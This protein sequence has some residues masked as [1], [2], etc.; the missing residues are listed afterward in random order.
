MR[1]KMDIYNALNTFAR[2]DANGTK[3]NAIQLQLK[4]KNTILLTTLT[5]SNKIIK[6]GM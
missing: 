6:S 1:Q 3:K 5:L 2:M 4:M